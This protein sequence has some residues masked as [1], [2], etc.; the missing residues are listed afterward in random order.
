MFIYVSPYTAL[1]LAWPVKW[2]VG[3]T[4]MLTVT[5]RLSENA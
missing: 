5:V 2:N 4:E 1:S 3:Q